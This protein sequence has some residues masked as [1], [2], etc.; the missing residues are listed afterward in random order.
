M[1]SKKIKEILKQ[2]DGNN[3]YKKIFI[4]GSWGIGKSYYTNEYKKEH[5]ENIIYISLFGKTSFESIN[6]SLSKELAKKLNNVDKFKKKAKQF[7]KNIQGS[8]SI[9][10]VSLNSP[11]I[12]NKTLLEE[13]SK[14]LSEKELIIIIDDLE[15]KSINIPIEDIM[16]LIEEFSTLEKVKIAIIGDESNIDKDDKVKWEKFKEKIIEKEYKIDCFSYD[17]IESIVINRLSLYISKDNLEE[18]ISSFLSKHKTKNL[19][20]I[21]KGIN[22]FIEIVENY[23]KEKYDETVYLTILKNCMSVAIE[24]TEELYKPKEEDKNSKDTT[25]SWAYNFDSEIPSRIVSHYF[26]SIFMNHKDASILD[27]VIKF[28]NS[29]TTDEIVENFN[30][31]LKNYINIKEEKNIFYLSE[32]EII[33]KV[34]KT[35]NDI[36]TKKYV[37]TTLE[38]FIDDIY[39]LLNYN[40]VFS[41][42]YKFDTISKNINNIL[43]AQYY[44]VAKEEYQ[45]QVDTFSLIKHES[46]ELYEVLN[47]YN[48]EVSK[49]YAIDKIDFIVTKYKTCDLNTDYL[50]F[51]KWKF[52]QQ[53][54]QNAKEYFF[55]CC[56]ENNFL[57]PNLDKELQENEW[58][59][60]HQIW[61]L[62]HDFLDTKYKIQ[63]NN[64][65]EE[66]KLKSNL[67]KYRVNAL[68]EYRPLIQKNKDK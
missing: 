45:N 12:N 52:I 4:N 67:V 30:N 14:L 66:L 50:S 8:I 61:Y 2:F 37:I 25:K 53:N 35:Y 22:L 55:K 58:A 65:A 11:S 1:E 63:L 21:N 51:L 39:N 38:E 26:G 57:L 28:Y 19:R 54:S 62:Y 46:K 16:G 40:N 20:T 23:V 68:Q 33:S 42:G 64:Y 17:A 29:E 31:V 10:G 32:K 36:Q 44:D 13:F 24:Y 5:Q 47:K 7:A 3:T 49:K 48:E 59:W 15:R 27:Y 6:D 43:F 18:F 9:C 56:K 41:L 34:E 60:T